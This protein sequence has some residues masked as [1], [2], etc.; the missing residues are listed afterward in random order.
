MD[1]RIGR[2]KIGERMTLR[3][4]DGFNDDELPERYIAALL[5]IADFHNISV[6]EAHSGISDMLEELEV[7]VQLDKD[8]DKVETRH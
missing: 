8:R 6:D 7:D 5:V 4:E 2:L 1:F 3:I